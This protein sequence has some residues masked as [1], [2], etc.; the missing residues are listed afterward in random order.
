MIKQSVFSRSP[1]R[2]DNRREKQM[3]IRT[4]TI[5]RLSALPRF[6]Y[7]EIYNFSASIQTHDIFFGSINVALIIP[8]GES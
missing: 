5:N 8:S 7:T 1:V 3:F 4:V 2:E 6:M